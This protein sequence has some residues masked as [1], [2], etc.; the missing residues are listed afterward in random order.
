[1]SAE[2]ATSQTSGQ[3]LDKQLGEARATMEKYLRDYDTLFNRTQ[4]LTEDLEDQVCMSR[5]T[6]YLTQFLFSYEAGAFRARSLMV[7]PGGGD[8]Q[9]AYRQAQFFLRGWR[10]CRGRREQR[11]ARAHESRPETGCAKHILFGREKNSDMTVTARV[12]VVGRSPGVVPLVLTPLDAAFS[13]EMLCLTPRP[14][15]MYKN[16]QLSLENINA[17]KEIKTKVRHHLKC[18]TLVMPYV[19]VPGESYRLRSHRTGCFLIP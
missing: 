19:V 3:T 4:K 16:S 8:L 5:G 11:P 15:Q 9:S 10:H 2:L 6:D 7:S 13:K 12:C 14:Q 17:D 1:M 18:A